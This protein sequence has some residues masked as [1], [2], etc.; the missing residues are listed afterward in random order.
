MFSF[1]FP[2]VFLLFVHQRQEISWELMGYFATSGIAKWRGKADGLRALLHIL[3]R[4]TEVAKQRIM[5]NPFQ[6]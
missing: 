3:G 1:G 2:M 6:Q 4:V 5:I